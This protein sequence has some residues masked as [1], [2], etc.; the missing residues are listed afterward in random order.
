MTAADA[1]SAMTEATRLSFAH[2]DPDTLVVRVAGDWSIDQ[3]PPRP[4]EV[5]RQLAATPAPRRVAFDASALGEWDSILLTFLLQVGEMARQRGIAVDRSGLPGGVQEL[6][7]IAETVPEREDAHVDELKAPALDRLGTEAIEV[8]SSVGGFVDFIGEVTAAFGRLLR[9]AAQYRKRDLWVEIQKA[10]VDALGIVAIVAFLLGLILSFVGAVQLQQ[11]GATIY[12]ADL[13]GIAMVHDMGALMTAIVLA[14]RS[15]AAYAAQLGSMQV[16]QEID[17][18]A[19]LGISPID[20]LVLPRVLAL[21]LMMPL[22]TLYADLVGILGGLMVGTGM[23]G[24]TA[25]VYIQETIKALSI[26]DLLGGLLKGAVY[27]LLVG[28]AGCMRG[29][30]SS[31]S[32]SGVGDAATSAVVT[33]IVAII[34]AAGLFAVTFYAIGI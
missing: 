25:Q 14:G 26:S 18:L 10:G 31:R 34:A 22:L 8:A 30:Q 23:L 32:A 19:T 33:A 24:L 20:F 15:G 28:L 17:A 1:A 27:G 5:D 3:V 7:T 29:M 2:T 21:V 13:V 9:G 11:F 12:V 4:V 6:L 16:N